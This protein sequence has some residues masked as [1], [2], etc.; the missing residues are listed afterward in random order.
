MSLL[1]VNNLGKSFGGVKAVDGISFELPPGELLVLPCATSEP[2][3]LIVQRER[4][5]NEALCVVTIGASTIRGEPIRRQKSQAAAWCSAPR[6]I[7]C[8][9][10]AGATAAE[11]KLKFES[12]LT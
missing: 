5:P 8:T 12:K 1:K 10:T 7:G 6:E 2:I 11:L 3:V 4:T 9:G